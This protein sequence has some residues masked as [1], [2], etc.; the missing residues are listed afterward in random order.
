M[1]LARNLT[2]S[3]GIQAEELSLDQEMAERLRA[4]G[5]ME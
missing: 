3:Q 2:T 4:L 1:Q 5:Y